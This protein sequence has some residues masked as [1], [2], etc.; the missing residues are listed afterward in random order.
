M[1]KLYFGP[2]ACSF[3]PLAALEI[4]KAATGDEF[5]LQL[6]KIHKGEQFAPEFKALNP[7]SLVPVLLVDGRPLTQIIAIAEY[8]DARYPQLELFPREPWARVRALSTMA[9]MNNTVHPAFTHV[10]MPQKFA[11]GDA[12]KAELKSHNLPLFQGYLERIDAEV[13]K[14]SPYWNGA[15]IG[16]LDL[17]AV[18]FLRWAGLAGIDPDSFPAYKAYVDRIA[19][20]PPVVAA[21]ADERQPLHYFKKAA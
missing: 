3:V 5:E 13:A 4:I 8:L 17:Y 21:L 11:A 19:A 7:D 1:L 12:A 18:V 15:K 20:L 9:W 10:F 2:G 14:A 6:V 16:F